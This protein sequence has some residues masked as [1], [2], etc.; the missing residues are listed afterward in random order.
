MKEIVALLGETIRY[1]RHARDRMLGERGIRPREVEEALRRGEI[2]EEYLE[3]RPHPSYLVLGQTAQG[4]SLH[5]VCAPVAEQRRLHIITVY[6]PD[7]T[8]W[9]DLRRRR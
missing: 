7:P 6:E 9:V 4:R 1:T 8:R 2:I 3:D 5:M